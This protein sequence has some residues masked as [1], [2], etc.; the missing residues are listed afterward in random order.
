MRRCAR[1]DWQPTGDEPEREQ[2]AAHAQTADHPLC[3]ICTRSLAHAEPATCETCLTESHTLLSGIVTM[4]NELPTHLGHLHGSSTGPRSSD[5]RPLP[6][7]NVLVMLAGGSEGL[8]EDG[9]TTRE[10]DYPSVAFELGWWALAWAGDHGDEAILGHTPARIVEKAAGYLERK[11]RWA[12]LRPGFE[13]FHTD[14]RR[15]HRGLEHATGRSQPRQVAEAD[16]FD[17]G[18]QLERLVTDKGSDDHWTCRRCGRVYT[19]EAY[20]LALRARLEELA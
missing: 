17:C 7:G 12:S 15:L 1:C 9:T 4:F 11:M 5:G 3:C 14:L 18:G 20:L 6:G 10:G 2:L 19:W 16:C 13:Q 8:A